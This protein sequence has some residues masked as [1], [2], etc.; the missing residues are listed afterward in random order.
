MIKAVFFDVDGT[1]VSF[2][3]HRI[4]ASSKK[5]IWK[6]RE[7]GVKVFLATGRHI[8][9]IPDMEG[10]VFD[11][12]ITINGSLCLLG[13]RNPIFKQCVS[14]KDIRTII[15]MQET[16]PFPCLVMDDNGLFINFKNEIVEEVLKMKLFPGLEIRPF[17][18]S[19]NNNIYQIVSFL[20][21]EQEKEV[22]PYIPDCESLRWHPAFTDFVPKGS[23]KAVGI[24]KL[25]ENFGIKLEETMAIGDGGNDIPMLKHAGIGVVMGNAA[26]DVKAVADYVTDSVDEDGVYNALVKLGVLF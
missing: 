16:N 10:L 1:L 21:V 23:S 17:E 13:D 22:L 15:K 9:S 3:T 8:L 12:Y 14:E 26:D 11:G 19:L 18:E 25:I 6:L 20:T 24:D 5:A 4:P 2:K 7:K